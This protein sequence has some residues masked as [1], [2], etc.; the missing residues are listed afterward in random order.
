[1]K[2]DAD[3]FMVSFFIFCSD[4]GT[5]ARTCKDIVGSA[6]TEHPENTGAQTLKES[7][8]GIITQRVNV[9]VCVCVLPLFHQSILRAG[10]DPVPTREPVLCVSTAKQPVLGPNRHQVFAGLEPFF[11]HVMFMSGAGLLRLLSFPS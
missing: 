2:G 1:V 9:C 10:S 7:V 5:L 4:S 8:R 6:R 11:Y 3:S